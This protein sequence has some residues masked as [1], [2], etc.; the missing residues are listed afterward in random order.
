MNEVGWH[1]VP[2]QESMNAIDFPDGTELEVGAY[3][4]EG[5]VT[6]VERDIDAKYGG[7]PSKRV[8]VHVRPYS[9]LEKLD[10]IWRKLWYGHC[11]MPLY[12][13]YNFFCPIYVPLNAG[14]DYDI[15][16]PK[17]R[18]FPIIWTVNLIRKS[19]IAYRR[20]QLRPRQ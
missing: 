6:N 1:F 19:Q 10:A 11:A 7:E 13:V 5:I 15:F 9:R 14:I 2:I 4:P 3:I 12:Y 16:N 8:R 17:R 18:P 20:W